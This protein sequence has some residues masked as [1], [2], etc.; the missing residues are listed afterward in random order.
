MCRNTPTR[1]SE[2]S[3]PW[4][5]L[6]ETGVNCAVANHNN[7]HTSR[8]CHSCPSISSMP[9]KHHNLTQS[10]TIWHNLTIF[11]PFSALISV[12]GRRHV[13]QLIVLCLQPLTLRPALGMAWG[14]MDTQYITQDLIAI[15]GGEIDQL[16]DLVG[17]K[18]Q[19]HVMICY[20]FFVGEIL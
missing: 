3:K 17:L 14:A 1:F 16:W 18:Q 13:S 7:H 8:M 11:Q 5:R 12:H 19:D 6:Q 20:V 4:I 15:D 10:D 2:C 9:N